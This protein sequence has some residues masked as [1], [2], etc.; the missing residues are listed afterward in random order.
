MRKFI[1]TV[2][3]VCSCLLLAASVNAQRKSRSQVEREFPQQRKHDRS[4]SKLR[5]KPLPSLGGGT[6]APPEPSPRDLPTPGTT[7]AAPAVQ[8]RRPIL[9]APQPPP[10]PAPGNTL[11]LPVQAAARPGK[12][13]EECKD[14]QPT[15]PGVR[16]VVAREVTVRSDFNS[17]FVGTLQRGDHFRVRAVHQIRRVDKDG[18]VYYPCYF[19]GDAFGNVDRRNVWVRCDGLEPRGETHPMPRRAMKPELHKPGSDRPNT[20][21]TREHL[22][23]RFASR[24]LP[25][26]P[27]RGNGRPNNITVKPEVGT[28]TVFGNYHPRKAKDPLTRGFLDPVDDPISLGDRTITLHGRYVTKDGNAVALNITRRDPV[29]KKKQKSWVFID[30]NTVRIINLPR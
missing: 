13:P 21:T 25:E 14:R 26:T 29:S 9:H 22:R 7:A 6:L 10:L 2:I 19:F 12:L 30:R 16:C 1:L 27:D 24:I 3:T 17:F 28:V 8:P 20:V 5:P 18:D 11:H 15:S 23:N 4:P